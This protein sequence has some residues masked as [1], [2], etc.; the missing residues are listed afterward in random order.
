MNR[1]LAEL[2]REWAELDRSPATTEAIER[3]GMKEPALAGA[4]SLAAVLGERRSRRGPEVLAA[5]ARL[6]AD[7]QLA[8][9][10]SPSGSRR[11]SA[12]RHHR[13]VRSL[14]VESAPAR[15]PT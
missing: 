9:R 15:T 6:A 14:V 8:A 5:L 7:D 13:A 12:G 10:T 3:W 4:R 1:T 11:R 2:E